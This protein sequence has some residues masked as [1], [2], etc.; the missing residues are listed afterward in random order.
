MRTVE[1][2]LMSMERGAFEGMMTELGL[3]LAQPGF[4]SQPRSGEPRRRHVAAPQDARL[5]LL[6][7][8]VCILS[9]TCQQQA[10]ADAMPWR[11]LCTTSVQ[12][13]GAEACVQV[14][15]VGK[16]FCDDFYRSKEEVVAAVAAPDASLVALELAL[17]IPAAVLLLLV[18]LLDVMTGWRTRK[19]WLSISDWV[20]FRLNYEK[21]R[22]LQN[23]VQSSLDSYLSALNPR[24]HL[25]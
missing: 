19:A 1:M 17:G 14:P 7:R 11:S 18:C 23:K 25:T 20:N 5:L 3:S 21:N 4:S 15:T 13:D 22:R 24:C 2:L 9:R 12:A 6:A 8:H 16:L 10:A